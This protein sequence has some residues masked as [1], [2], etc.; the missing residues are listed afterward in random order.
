M[1]IS[2]LA[3]DRMR[4]QKQTKKATRS[5]LVHFCRGTERWRVRN[6]TIYKTSISYYIRMRKRVHD[7]AAIKSDLKLIRYF[8]KKFLSN[9][10]HNLKYNNKYLKNK[11]K[12]S[13]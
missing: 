11:I 1:I 6:I 12:I 5:H 2:F 13:K 9:I 4:K 10:T 7:N 8:I 3:D